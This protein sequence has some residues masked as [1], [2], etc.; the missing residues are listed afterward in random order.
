[1]SRLSRQHCSSTFKIILLIINSHYY[2]HLYSHD[3]VDACEILHHQ[4]DG[5]CN[6]NL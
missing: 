6:P 5:L 1:M 2:I 4:K 3:T